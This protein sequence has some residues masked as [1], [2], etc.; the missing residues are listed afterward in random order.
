MTQGWGW[1]IASNYLTGDT[2]NTLDGEMDTTE[3]HHIIE[4]AQLSG[5]NNANRMVDVQGPTPCPLAHHV[6][7]QN[8]QQLH[9]VAEA[10]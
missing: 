6:M 4:I 9:R 7:A 2:V 10:Q 3:S 1:V 5:S 8:P